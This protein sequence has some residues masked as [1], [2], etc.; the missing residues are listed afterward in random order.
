MDGAVLRVDPCPAAFRLERAVRGL[1]AGPVGARA[2]TVRHLVETVAQRLRPDL[3]RLKQNIMLGIAC[4]KLSPLVPC[5]VQRCGSTTSFVDK[6]AA[7]VAPYFEQIGPEV[8][9]KARVDPQ[10]EDCS[11]LRAAPHVRH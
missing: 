10:R 3:D 8:M 7:E 1:E 9:R 5:W 11:A 4:H 6:D 2:D